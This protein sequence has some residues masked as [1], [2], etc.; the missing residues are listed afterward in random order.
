M[1]KKKPTRKKVQEK[2]NVRN[3]LEQIVISLA[4]ENAGK[5]VELLYQKQNVNEFLIAKK[6][7]LTI[8]Q[9]RNILYKLADDGLVTF[10]RKKDVKKGGWYTYFWTIKTK[11]GLIKLKEGLQQKYDELHQQVKTRETE[12]HFY[13]KNCDIEYNEEDAM[14]LDYTCSECGE[15]LEIREV[16]K[17]T[18]V[19]KE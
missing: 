5:L 14:L 17:M 12:R 9:T 16:E 6:L 10:I 19:I 7:N 15:V 18:S 2:D 1:S 11:R 8:N 3:F 4:G 13:C